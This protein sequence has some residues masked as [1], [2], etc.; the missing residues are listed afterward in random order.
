MDL[1]AAM[2]PCSLGYGEIGRKLYDDPNTKRGKSCRV[3]MSLCFIN[4]NLTIHMQKE[5]P[6]GSG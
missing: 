3:I 4:I 2:A 1:Q 6:T 5:T